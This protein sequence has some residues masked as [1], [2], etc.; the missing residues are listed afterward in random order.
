M[1]WISSH[2]REDRDDRGEKM[3]LRR[4]F[5]NNFKSL[6]AVAMMILVSFSSNTFAQ[7]AK[8]LSDEKAPSKNAPA[9]TKPTEADE[10][11]TFFEKD[12]VKITQNDLTAKETKQ[13]PLQIEGDKEST[14]LFT[15]KDKRYLLIGDLS[16]GIDSRVKLIELPSGAVGEENGKAYVELVQNAN[17]QINAFNKEKNSELIKL[18]NQ[19]L[20]AFEKEKGA[21][22]TAEEMK[23]LNKSLGEELDTK[24]KAQEEELE[25]KLL[26]AVTLT[27]DANGNLVFGDDHKVFMTGYKSALENKSAEFKNMVEKDASDAEE[28]A[29]VAK[30]Q[31][32]MQKLHEEMAKMPP[33]EKMLSSFAI[34]MMQAMQAAT[35]LSHVQIIGLDEKGINRTNNFDFKNFK[36]NINGESIDYNSTNAPSFFDPTRK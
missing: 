1:E 22:I 30:I 6:G 12:G 14:Y 17:K 5:M 15:I 34:Y 16:D 26:P 32:Q 28:A 29:M 36:A 19:R 33:Q 3:N 31:E 13:L 23:K 9:Q 35:N 10:N 11:P 21:N 2:R 25:K 4:N 20:K 24:Y 8:E 27:V 18:R 7:R